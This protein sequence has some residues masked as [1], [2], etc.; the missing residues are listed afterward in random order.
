MGDIRETENG[1]LYL[2]K[3]SGACCLKGSLHKGTPRGQVVTIAGVETYT[4]APSTDKA[5]GHIL[6]YFPD[7]WGL[8]NNG[9][10]IMDGFANDGFLVLGLDYFRGDP[11]WKHRKDRN[12]RSNPDFD[13]EGWKKK[14]TAF[15][16]VAVQKWVKEVKE[17]YGQ[18]NTKYVC[19]GYCFGAPY[20]CDQLAGD[21]VVAGAFAHP[22]F[23]KEHHFL[24]LK[25]TDHTFN[26]DSR[27][28]AVDILI[29]G[30]K[31]YQLQVFSRV[32]HGFA[33]RGDMNNPY[34]RYVKERSLDGIVKWF[35]F[36]L[37][38]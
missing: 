17:A 1:N 20:V 26:V 30:N 31:S 10:L 23:L 18:P 9:L 27:R 13:Y 21:G 34:E 11:V 4:V 3:P 29:E 14:H 24:N 32:E 35:E 15:A 7:V 6:L 12:D 19:V 25:K 38:Q 33:L 5:N 28:R 37:S 16:D 36:W 8:F 2:A 22:A